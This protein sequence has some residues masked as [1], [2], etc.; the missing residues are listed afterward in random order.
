MVR[1]QRVEKKVTAKWIRRFLAGNRF[2]ASAWT[3]DWE[4]AETKNGPAADSAN[5]ESC[6]S[7]EHV[8]GNP[9]KGLHGYSVRM[10]IGVI[11][12]SADEHRVGVH[13]K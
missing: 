9:L 13:Q 7:T 8:L 6:A 5:T 1:R 10:P 2:R 4:K 12:T 11:N 3:T